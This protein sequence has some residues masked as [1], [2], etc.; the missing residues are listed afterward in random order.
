MPANRIAALTVLGLRMAYG[1]GLLAAP[2]RLSR[3]WL[4]DGVIARPRGCR[5]G[6]SGC[7]RSCCTPVR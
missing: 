6:R 5:C 2:G 4:G 1:A 7:G 3:R